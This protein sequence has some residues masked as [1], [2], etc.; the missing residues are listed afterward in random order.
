[1]KNNKSIFCA[2]LLLSFL[3]GT[4]AV[5]KHAAGVA[6]QG[7]AGGE[8]PLNTAPLTGTGLL[9]SLTPTVSPMPQGTMNPLTGLPL[10]DPAYVDLS[11]VL[12]SVS[13]FPISVRPQA[14]LSFAPHVFEMTI[15]EGMT[16]FLAVYYG[17][18][19][20]E[21]QMDVKLG[22][23]R[24]GRLPYEDLRTMYDGTVVMAGAAPD[25]GSKLSATVFRES[26]DFNGIK[27]LAVDRT[28][29][30]G[31]P[32]FAPIYADSGLQSGG[33]PGDQL[34]IQ[35]NYLNRV[36]WT[37]DESVGKYLRE[38]D[39]S[40][41]KDSF[42]PAID[43]L[44]TEQ[45]ALDNVV[46]MAVEHIY[47]NPTKIEMN[48]AYVAKEPAIFF[49]DGQAY[50]VYWSTLAPLGPVKFYYLD[51]TPFPYKPGNTWFEIISS[52]DEVG[53]KEDGSWMVQFFNP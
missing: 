28:K 3:A 25:V 10:E 31:A 8:I 26:V 6:P 2:A 45:L 49:R 53:Q 44:T 41:G 13:N 35:W 40:D 51:G 36:R 16:R 33:L 43:K 37:F 12:V 47:L 48:L 46:L 4:T 7:S 24:S 17:S 20:P 5:T 22:S 38:Q 50:R 39:Q 11:P 32:E 23:I 9:P 19:G 52:L 27:A 21:D 29:R 15:G 42:V 1:M 30:K 14:G 18:Y 34:K